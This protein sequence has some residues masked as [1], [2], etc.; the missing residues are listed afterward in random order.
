MRAAGPPP[1]E[2]DDTLWSE[3]AD[4]HLRPL[5]GK[6]R[7]PGSPLLRSRPTGINTPEPNPA[8]RTPSMA[9]PG[10]PDPGPHRQALAHTA[11][12]SPGTGS[13]LAGRSSVGL[14]THAEYW[15]AL[16]FVFVSDQI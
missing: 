9:F 12:H 11:E 7:F 4:S 6:E 16:S 13:C 15:W 2:K 1:K 8:L 3:R 10:Q 14:R 5:Q